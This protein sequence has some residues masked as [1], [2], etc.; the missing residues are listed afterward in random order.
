LPDSSGDGGT[1]PPETSA[2]AA[3]APSGDQSPDDGKHVW[4]RVLG[5]RHLPPPLRRIAEHRLTIAH[6]QDMQRSLSRRDPAQNAA[7]RLPPG[8]QAR[9]PV[10]WLAEIFT[11]TTID[12]LAH[13]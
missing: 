9:V 10:I 11:P 8:E 7:T 3:T 12:G 5:F 13:R 2:D 4:K 6:A 1:P